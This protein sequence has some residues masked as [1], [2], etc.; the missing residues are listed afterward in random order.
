MPVQTPLTPEQRGDEAAV[1]YW[2]RFG[3][4]LQHI[5]ALLRAA[6]DY[7]SFD[8]RGSSARSYGLVNIA[9]ARRKFDNISWTLTGD[10]YGNGGVGQIVSRW[11]DPE[12]RTR[13][14]SAEQQTNLLNFKGYAVHLRDSGLIYLALHEMAHVTEPG[15][16]IWTDCWNRHQQLGGTRE[17]YPN[18]PDWKYNEQFAN[19]IVIGICDGLGLIRPQF[20]PNPGYLP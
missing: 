4:Q 16:R 8:I 9:D 14:R 17:T 3:Y 10:S 20:M 15:I 7:V 6:P 18:S 11:D 12:T 5:S 19:C 1:G 2:D 13:W